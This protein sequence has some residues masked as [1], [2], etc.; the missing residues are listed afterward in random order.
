MVR[1]GGRL[2]LRERA[3]RY[4][5]SVGLLN[6]TVTRDVSIGLAN[7]NPP[8][9]WSGALPFAA[10]P[11]DGQ[12]LY[13]YF[14][15]TTSTLRAVS[16][17]DGEDRLIL[18]IDEVLHQAI[19][20]PGTDA[21]YYLALD[22]ATRGELGIFRGTVR[23]GETEQL[24]PPRFSPDATQIASKLFLTPDASR[25]VSHDCRDDECRL[26]AY[27]AANGDLIFDVAAPA[28]DAFG[29]TDSEVIL[30]GASVSVGDG[31]PQVPCAAVA[32]DLGSGRK[33]TLGNVCGAAM[34]VAAAGGPMLVSDGAPHGQ[35]APE[36]VPIIA[37]DIRTG[38]V[39]AEFPLQA[40]RE[41]VM[42]TRDQ[43]VGLPQGWFLT[44]RAGQFYTLDPAAEQ[45]TLTLVRI[46][47]RLDVRASGSVVGPSLKIF[48]CQHR[49]GSGRACEA[50]VAY[51]VSGS[52]PRRKHLSRLLTS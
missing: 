41:L 13:G 30:S 5:L 32:F 7:L 40:A 49:L 24:V 28:S 51:R 36:P 29:I 9:E 11:F 17:E 22:P 43:A 48:S 39:V 10:G 50:D 35:C 2:R 18:E 44:G 19:L 25:L 31:C 12:V 47:K 16:A 15:G 4:R 21:F 34:V 6:G 52:R 37:T 20:D 8:S 42:N 33:R 38:G 1:P 23:G 45:N 26:R 14:D 3:A 27:A 46:D